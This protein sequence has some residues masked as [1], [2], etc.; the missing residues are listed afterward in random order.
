M[1][2]LIITLILI[3]TAQQA[4]AGVMLS[5]FEKVN[6][7]LS[8]NESIDVA[9]ELDV[10]ADEKIV[11]LKVKAQAIGNK[12]TLKVSVNNK[13]IHQKKLT[14]KGEIIALNF[15]QGIKDKL[16]ISSNSAFVEI[17]KAN[18]VA[19]EPKDD[20]FSKQGNGF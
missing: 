7:Y 11:G 16:K 4:Q 14:A 1:K 12:S 6:S 15:K 3:C 9:K 5:L 18:L 19:D 20:D 10:Q 8:S 17:V 2:N 13:V